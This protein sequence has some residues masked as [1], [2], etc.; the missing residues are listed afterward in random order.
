MPVV[1]IVDKRTNPYDIQVQA[2][3]ENTCHDNSISGATQFPWR[4]DL[5]CFSVGNTT[6]ERAIQYASEKW[7]WPITLYIYDS[8]SKNHCDIPSI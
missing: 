7:S 2:I 4:E 8:N 3:F 5:V 6:I 1:N